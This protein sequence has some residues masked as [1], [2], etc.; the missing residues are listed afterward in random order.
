MEKLNSVNQTKKKLNK[1]FI[2]IERGKKTKMK[3]YS[4]LKKFKIFWKWM[5]Q[6]YYR[7]LRKVIK[8]MSYRI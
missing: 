2:K 3:M 4:C 6:D 7:D 1:N 5:E 8:R